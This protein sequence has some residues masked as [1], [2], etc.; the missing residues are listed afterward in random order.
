MLPQKM[1]KCLLQNLELKHCKIRRYIRICDYCTSI[2][3][4]WNTTVL[5][6]NPIAW[7]PRFDDYFRT[8]ICYFRPSCCFLYFIYLL[9]IVFS[10]VFCV[11]F[12][13]PYCQQTRCKKSKE[14]N[15]QHSLG[16]LPFYPFKDAN[17]GNC[18]AKIFVILVFVHP[19][20]AL[21]SPSARCDLPWNKKNMRNFKLL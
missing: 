21:R 7:T 3:T 10:T 6:V 19:G 13:F 18:H 16:L 1:V 15:H 12:C 17:T 2:T 11:V 20:I 5:V 4:P 14:K 9:S 8:V